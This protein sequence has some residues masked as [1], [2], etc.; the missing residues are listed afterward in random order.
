M[1]LATNL[2]KFSAQVAI[3]SDSGVTLTYTE[4]ALISDAIFN[5]NNAPSTDSLI[6]IE[7]KN[8]IENIASYLGALRAGIPAILIDAELNIELKK[9]LYSYYGVTHIFRD[10][11]WIINSTTPIAIHRDIALLL[12]TSGSTG[13]QKLV[14]LS[15]K[16]LQ[17]NAVAI[18]QYL[19]INCTERPITVLPIH[20]SYGLS[21]INSH[22]YVG[23]TILLTSEPITSKRFWEHF[24]EHG[25]TSFAGVP[26]TYKILKQLRFE[27]MVLPTLKSFT[28]AGGKLNPVII[29][30]FNNYALSKDM[31]FF[32]MYGQT[33]ATA[34]IAYIP[35]INLS[36]K[37]NSIG[38]SIPG[39]QISLLNE[40][41]EVI[42]SNFIT[43][44]LCYRGDNVMLGYA[45]DINSLSEGDT[46]H[47][48][49]R[50]GDLAWRDED[51]YYYIA[52]RLKRFIKIFGNRI[53]LDEIEAYLQAEHYDVAVTGE[54][55]ALM[56]A[57][58]TDRN[59]VNLK[60]N[61]SSRHH[62]H[63]SAIH[64]FK[65][66]DFPLSSSGKILYAN[67]L[68]QLKS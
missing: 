31:Q 4:L 40:T 13:S 55:D 28:Q 12:S 64:I 25:A 66:E 2:E 18:S 50:T 41:D 52:G 23:A 33:E 54:D 68:M 19:E 59:T 3:I 36:N 47:G 21:I 16:N 45:T 10:N 43:G 14:K 9:N 44:E 51:G 57:I 26:A 6:A 22:L 11:S 42:S 8:T 48:F 56:I 62:L 53:G 32:V 24:R 46:Q 29:E 34:R 58:R 37:T 35:P 7:C 17:A 1:N 67:L 20:Y 63:S 65:V 27:R 30:W 5:E 60:N 49:I 15:N 39:G 61:I 38:I